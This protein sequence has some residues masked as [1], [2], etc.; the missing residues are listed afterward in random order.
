MGF[1][2]EPDTTKCK[3]TWRLLRLLAS[4]SHKEWMAIGDFNEIHSHYEKLGG[5]P[6]P[7][8]RLR[9]FRETLTHNDLTDLGFIGYPFTWT[10]VQEIP[11]NTKERLDIATVNPQWRI[12]FPNAQLRHLTA[13]RSDNQPILTVLSPQ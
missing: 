8:W 2:G 10:N 13:R 11:H 9:D 3:S 1:N 5:V 12:L 6:T 4:H 7:E